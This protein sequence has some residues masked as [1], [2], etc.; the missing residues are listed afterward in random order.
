M[1]K[2]STLP[3]IE[4]LAENRA[5]APFVQSLSRPLVVEAVRAVVADF[6]NRVKQGENIDEGELVKTVLVRLEE[7]KRQTL[8]KVI[9][10]TGIIL[11]TNLG[12]APLSRASLEKASALLSGYVNLEFDLKTGGRGG[13]GAFVED[14]LCLLSGA[15]AAL[16][17][18]NNASALYLALS[19]LARGREVII[20]R[21]ELVQ[22]GGGFKIPEILEEAGAI[23]KEIGTTNRTILAD[24][25]KAINAKT[26]LILKV[27]TSN[28]KQIGFVDSV[29][30][31][32]LAS[33]TR[34]RNILLVEDL[35]SGAFVPTERF[36]LPREPLVSAAV[37]AGCDLVTFSGDKLLAGPQAGIAVGK[38][39][40]VNRLKKSSLF[41]ALRVD[42]L[43][44]LLL[45]ETLKCY[46]NQK[47]TTELPA[48]RLL[49]ASV[50]SLK[51][52]AEN[53]IKW[54]GKSGLEAVPTKSQVGGGALPE[55]SLLSWGIALPEIYSASNWEEKLRSASPPILGKIVK[56]R[57][58]IDLRAVFPEEDA[59]LIS[60]LKPLL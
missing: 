19:V 55:E 52:R 58:I 1:T 3:S 15:E 27:H 25:E 60:A 59:I 11:H 31:A 21:G 45:E 17:V 44:L 34:S 39:E 7:K 42:K 18:N 53:I 57:F 36:D 9:N 56:D 28:F 46:L 32:E 13:R 50:E 51:S 48:Y 8:M 43:Y 35:G 4:K 23:L 6:R 37:E 49:S 5:F 47:V 16:V 10:A 29:P 20:S 22:I 33:L 54:V 26:V 2:L 14:L 38:K 41:R 40:V 30:A 24:Y 12:R